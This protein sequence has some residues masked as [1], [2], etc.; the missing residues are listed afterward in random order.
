LF[1][2]D[3]SIQSVNKNKL[4]DQLVVQHKKIVQ[5]HSSIPLITDCALPFASK[6]RRVER[7]PRLREEK[8]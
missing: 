7:F 8:V 3:T 1:P 4:L 2:V 5:D 6:V